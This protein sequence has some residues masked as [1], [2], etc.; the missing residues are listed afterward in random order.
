MPKVEFRK[1]SDGLLKTAEGEA[2]GEIRV[3]ICGKTAGGVVKPILVDA[4]GKVI[5]V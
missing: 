2:T 3:V 5:T 4:D 1:T